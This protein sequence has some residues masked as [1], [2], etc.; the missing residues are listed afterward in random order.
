MTL[1]ITVLSLNALD[2]LNLLTYMIYRGA[3][4]KMP[5]LKKIVILFSVDCNRSTYL[6][7]MQ[8]LVDS[9]SIRTI[10]FV[11]WIRAFM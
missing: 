7:S 2:L 6:C 3:C 10:T 8:R 4:S 9:L 1:S 5:T 11:N